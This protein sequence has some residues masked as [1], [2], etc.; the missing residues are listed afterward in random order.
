MNFN[1]TVSICCVDWSHSTIVGDL[2][3]KSLLEV[4]NGKDLFD[5]R[6]MHLRKERSHNRACTDCQFLSTLPDYLDDAAE[7]IL[8]KILPVAVEKRL[9]SQK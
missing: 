9:N 3:K 6:C 2:T 1:G 8:A 4:W 7:T 5:F